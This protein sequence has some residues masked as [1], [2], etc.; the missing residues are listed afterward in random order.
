MHWMK[1]LT[2]VSLIE[3]IRGWLRSAIHTSIHNCTLHLHRYSFCVAQTRLRKHLCHTLWGYVKYGE[4]I[5]WMKII[6]YSKEE[7]SYHY[8]C[9]KSTQE[10]Y[11]YWSHSKKVESRPKWIMLSQPLKITSES[12]DQNYLLCNIYTKQFVC[13][14]NK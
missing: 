5:F 7:F 1:T 4:N 2:L 6:R 9:P 13:N 14:L 11:S 3:E 10:P 12:N 8:P